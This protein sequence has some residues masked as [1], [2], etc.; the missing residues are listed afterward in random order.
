LPQYT[1]ILNATCFPSSTSHNS[2][3]DRIKRSSRFWRQCHRPHAS[4][5]CAAFR[6]S[7]LEGRFGSASR[8]G[9]KKNI[10]IAMCFTR[11]MTFQVKLTIKQ[12]YGVLEH[13]ACKNIRCHTYVHPPCA[14][15]PSLFRVLQS[16]PDTIIPVTTQGK[17]DVV[18]DIEGDLTFS[19]LYHI[20]LPIF[21]TA[22]FRLSNGHNQ[23]IGIRDAY[24]D[25]SS[26]IL[27]NASSLVNVCQKL[28]RMGTG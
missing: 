8:I 7:H 15:L 26:N 19:A 12:F 27:V 18:W 3:S 28:D 4:S 17:N 25:S 24:L 11:N 23:E 10:N 13:K 1:L 5:K 14:V 22:K 6:V 2:R 20:R 9:Q 16:L 21:S